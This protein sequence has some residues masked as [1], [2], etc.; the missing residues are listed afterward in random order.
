MP[1]LAPSSFWLAYKEQLRQL[2][3]W[4]AY[5]S[6]SAW[7]PIAKLAADNACSQFGLHVSHEYYRLDVLGWDGNPLQR[8]DWNCR[9]A[10]EIEDSADWKDGLCKLSHIVC[11]LCVL[12]SYERHMGWT[13]ADA[14]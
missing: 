8:H 4:T 9:V 11:D 12:V 10:F 2:G 14:L 3:S 7:T 6:T 5:Q 1:E 13:C